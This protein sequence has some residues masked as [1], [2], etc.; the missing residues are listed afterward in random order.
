MYPIP[1]PSFYST[2]VP[3]S[4]CIGSNK[5]LERENREGEGETQQDHG[6]AL[7]VCSKMC[8]RVCVWAELKPRARVEPTDRIRL[9]RATVRLLTRVSLSLSAVH[10]NV[11][12]HRF[13][14]WSLQCSSI[15]FRCGLNPCERKGK[16]EEVAG[17]LFRGF[18][19]GH[20]PASLAHQHTQDE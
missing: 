13:K 8:P 6:R 9:E 12:V 1:L 10:V 17:D 11:L 4:G 7:A 18:L 14:Y 15:S 16:K 20:S 3:R 5:N 19:S 2:T